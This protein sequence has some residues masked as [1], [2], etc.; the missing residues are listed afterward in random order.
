MTKR[1]Q[2]LAWWRELSTKEK[3]ALM[4][5]YSMF[6]GRFANT[7]TGREIQMIWEGDM[8]RCINTLDQ[9]SNPENVTKR[10]GTQRSPFG[11][12]S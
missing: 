9:C 6:L 4:S 5:Q 8:T 1:S 11:I 10:I 12:G 2:A 3:V 7:L